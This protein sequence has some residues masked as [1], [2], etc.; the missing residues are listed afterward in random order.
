MKGQEKVEQQFR[1]DILSG[2]WEWRMQHPKA[3]FVEIEAEM[4]KRI[5]RLRARMLEEIIAMSRAS[6]WPAEEVIDCPQCGAKM[7]RQ[8]KQKRK[9]QGSGGSEIEIER[10]YAECPACGA[11]FFPS[12]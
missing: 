3:T 5:A 6:D 2:M 7:E 4:E 8:G 9:L 10:E 12:G 1:E 11:G